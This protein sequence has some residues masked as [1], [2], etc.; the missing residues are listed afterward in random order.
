MSENR[1]LGRIYSL[2]VDF[3][4]FPPSSEHIATVHLPTF[5]LPAGLEH[6]AEGL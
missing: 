2:F 5:L 3:P 4:R 6:R 1:Q